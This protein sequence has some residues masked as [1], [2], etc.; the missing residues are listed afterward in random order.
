MREN[1]FSVQSEK[2][3]C[4]AGL[5]SAPLTGA[6]FFSVLLL[7]FGGAVLEKSGLFRLEA[8]GAF[9]LYRL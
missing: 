4:M 6:L 2:L 7:L 5:C 9:L 3:F 1:N 8:D